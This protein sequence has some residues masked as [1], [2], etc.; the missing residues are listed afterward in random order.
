MKFFPLPRCMTAVM[1]VMLAAATPANLSSPG[2]SSWGYIYH[3]AKL[4]DEY[5]ARAF[6][7]GATHVSMSVVWQGSCGVAVGTAAEHMRRPSVRRVLDGS[8]PGLKRCKVTV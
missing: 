5:L 2:N 3:A 7:L 6:V 4:S 8:S 1:T